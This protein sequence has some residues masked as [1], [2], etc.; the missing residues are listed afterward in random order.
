MSKGTSVTGLEVKNMAAVD[1]KSRKGKS[2]MYLFFIIAYF[3]F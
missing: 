3:K 1:I 2:R